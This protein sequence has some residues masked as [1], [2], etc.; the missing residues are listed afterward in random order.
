MFEPAVIDAQ[1]ECERPLRAVGRCRRVRGHHRWR[2]HCVATWTRYGLYGVLALS[3]FYAV[4]GS[5]L[6]P[7]L[8][9]EPLGP[10]LKIAPIFVLHRLALEIIDERRCSISF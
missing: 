2:Q 7:D 3:L 10:L 4:A 9:I 6:L 8:W 1:H 5:I